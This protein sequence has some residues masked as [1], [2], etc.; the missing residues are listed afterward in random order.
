MN[1]LCEIVGMLCLNRVVSGRRLHGF[2]CWFLSCS[3]FSVNVYFIPKKATSCYK[4]N[5]WRAKSVISVSASEHPG[6]AST[7]AAPFSCT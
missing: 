3:F 4:Y 1:L 7:N 6:Q 2:F 5:Y